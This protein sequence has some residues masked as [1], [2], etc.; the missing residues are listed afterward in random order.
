MKLTPTLSLYLARLYAGNFLGIGAILLGIVYLFDTVELLRRA[1]KRADVPLSL[2]LEMGLYKL[3]EV[4]QIILPFAVLF[5]AIFSFWVLGRRHELVVVRAAGFSVW[6]FLAPVMGV[7]GL[8]GILQMGAINPVGAVMLAK[9][10][11]LESEHLMVGEKDLVTLFDRGLWLRQMLPGNQG[12]VVLH[13]EKIILPTWEMKGVMALFFG[14]DDAF[15]KRID[16]GGARL[17]GGEWVFEGALVHQPR[18]GVESHPS[19]TLPTSLTPDDI[20]ES[21]A[22]P[23]AHSFWRLP[24]YIKTL[25]QAG[26]DATRLRIHFH[27]LLAQPVLFA[28]MI[29]LAAAVSLRPQRFQ[30]TFALMASGVLMGFLVFFISSF[31]QAL[32]ASQQIPVLLAAWSPSVVTLLLGV[33]V[34]LGL[35]DG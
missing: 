17:Q 7:A 31:L 27:A 10:E 30:H 16:A 22:S 24:S 35:E 11:T 34:I 9:Y 33:A 32:G 21:F 18:Q 4:G 26:F 19:L 1:S 3:P 25:S 5:S 23:M 12:Y 14:A 13:A 2:V 8:I 29:L 6:Q 28:A 15:E 20:E